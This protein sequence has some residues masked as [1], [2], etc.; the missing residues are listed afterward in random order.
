MS[1]SL[2]ALAAS[3]VAVTLSACQTTSPDDPKIAAE[4]FKSVVQN[5]S[6]TEEDRKMDAGRDPS[7]FLAFARVGAGMDVLDVSAGAGYT[8]KL[9]ALAVGQTGTVWAQRSQPGP[10]LTKRLQEN[11]QANLVPVVRSFEDPVPDEA[12]PL[13]LVTLV[14]NY[15]DI[16]YLPVDRDKMNHRIFAALKAGGHYVI[17]DHAAKAG[18]EIGV[19]K[20]LHRIDEAIVLREVEAA[21]FK[22]EAEGSFLRNPADNREGRSY[23]SPIPTDKF[24]LRFVKP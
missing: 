17:V 2:A 4:R 9:L 3:L 20:T 7:D 13:D 18:A 5:P 10:A 22:L 24:A 21:G 15:H 11:P 6:R 23:D 16:T 19:G 8:S 12:P 14:N 1:W